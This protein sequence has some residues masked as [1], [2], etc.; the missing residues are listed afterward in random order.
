M[1]LDKAILGFIAGSSFPALLLPF[2]TLGTAMLLRPQ[3]AIPPQLLLWGL[4][5]VMGLW[6][7]ALLRYAPALPG[8]GGALTC[9]LAGALIGLIFTTL[10]VS[11]GAPGKLY[12]LHGALAFIMIPVGM[13]AH[14]FI[15]G[16]IVRQINR[17]MGLL[18]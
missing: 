4:P 17:L 18:P 1:S 15:W 7:I 8:Q 9:W 13:T 14:G 10:G 16:V 2:L 5:P 3:E 12:G 11:T 6:N